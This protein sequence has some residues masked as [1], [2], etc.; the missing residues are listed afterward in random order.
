[1]GDPVGSQEWVADMSG[2]IIFEAYHV[3]KLC[4]NPFSVTGKNG[5][6]LDTGRL[7]DAIVN[8][9]RGESLKISLTKRGDLKISRWPVRLL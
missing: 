5:Q 7:L 8:L 4:L 1:M 3:A 6:L 9:E 2:P